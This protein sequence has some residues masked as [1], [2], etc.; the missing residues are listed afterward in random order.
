M[1]SARE[2]GKPALQQRPVVSSFLY[3]FVDENGER[4]AKVALFK[5]S[6]QV[7][8]YQYRWAVVSGSIDP[9][10][11]SPQAAAWREI[12]EETTLTESSLELMRQG[13]SYVLPDESIGR[14][15]TIFPFA[16]RLKEASEGGKGE[17][18]IQL[19]WEHE[20]WAWYDP[21]EVE[22]SERFGAVPR[23]AESLRRV[24]FEKDLGPEAGAVLTKGL[25]KLKT[26]YGSGAR[27]LAGNA[28]EIL[29]DI[30]AK[31]DTHQPPEQWWTRVRFASWH[32]WKNGRESMGAAVL[33]ALLSALRGIERR[34]R[35]LNGKPV[36]GW[37][38]A[39]LD[40]L[41]RLVV[42]RRDAARAI[43]VTLT[44]FLE[45]QMASDSRRVRTVKVLTISESST[46]TCA[47]REVVANSDI[48]LDLRILESRP[49]F[50]GVSLASELSKQV[51]SP[52]ASTN[53]PISEG[54]QRHTGSAPKLLI[55]LY[56]DASSAL[57]SDNVDVVLIG[58]VRIAETGAVSNKTGSLPAILSAKHVSPKAKIVIISETEKVATP[59]A[60]GA[61]VVEN[62]DPA[63][64]MH[65]WTAGFN[66]ERIRTAAGTLPSRHCAF[67]QH[68][69][70]RSNHA[71]EVHVSNVS[72][73]WIPP[74]LIDVYLTERGQ[75]TVEDIAKLSETLGTEEERFF[76]DI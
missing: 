36:A 8:T 43:T 18:A 19:D 29:S 27:Q 35:Q 39:A 52:Q 32:I 75:L 20:T 51:P 64:L 66:G 31:M 68:D 12:R 41:D 24:W 30:V 60:A 21:F 11:P 70:N 17:D 23:L 7:R 46:I 76:R 63:Q 6:G 26:D 49:L 47:L 16:F 22:D 69:N 62:N 56:T 9:E 50:E 45:K 40:E 71:A 44:N 73:E 38:D 13:K 5:R 1:A 55:T 33:S 48:S 15:W 54:E 25:E 61:H 4:K 53:E 10:D 59:G 42:S 14:E 3:K 67:A 58:S 74:D 28:L 65:A 2:A 57:A 34:I 37:R 72:F